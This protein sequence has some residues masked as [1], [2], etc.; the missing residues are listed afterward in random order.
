LVKFQEEL[1]GWTELRDSVRQAKG[2]SVWESESIKAL[3]SNLAKALEEKR[4]QLGGRLNNPIRYRQVGGWYTEEQT[5]N[6]YPRCEF[7]CNRCINCIWLPDNEIGPFE[8]DVPFREPF[9]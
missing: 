6:H 1:K 5:Y 4:Q 8:S 9:V 3:R 7:G 2:T